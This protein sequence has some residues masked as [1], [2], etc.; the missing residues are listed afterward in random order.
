MAVI[1]A[2][3]KVG[4]IS[5]SGVQG[6]MGGNEGQFIT[7]WPRCSVSLPTEIWF[8]SSLSPDVSLVEK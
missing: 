1:Q 4:I 5:E 7:C 2:S 6:Y 3:L 8:G